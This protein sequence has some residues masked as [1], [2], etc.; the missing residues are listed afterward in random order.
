MLLRTFSKAS[1]LTFARSIL[2][3]VSFSLVAS[4]LLVPASHACTGITLKAKDGSVVYGRTMEWGSFDMESE[5]M[6][7]PPGHTFK[8]LLADGKWGKTW[9]AKFAVAGINGVGK[10]IVLDGINSA[11]LTIGLFY[12][13]GFA[14]YQKFDPAL[15]AESLAPTDVATYLLTTCDSV[16]AVRAALEKVRV[17]PVVEPALGIVAP[18]H[19]LVT[20]PSGRAI[21]VE[22]LRG[23]LKIFDAPL[24]TITNAP[25]YDWHETNLR[26]YV[27]LSAVSIPDKKIGDLDFKPLGGGNGSGMIGLPGDFTPPSR[28]IRA[29]AFTQTARPTAT[30]P[31]TMYELFRILDNFNVTAGAAE[32]HGTATTQPLRSA[33]Q[34]TTA[35]DTKSHT[36]YYH[37]MNNRRVRKVEL[38]QIK[39][40]DTTIL[41]QP[42]D[43]VKAEDIE[44]ATPGK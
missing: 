39:F 13:P 33:T 18:V 2:A 42:L 26:N 20:E 16:A 34:W 40:A 7:V 30:G 37:T 9:T 3:V 38:D 15:A 44:D 5:V 24:G 10:E 41:R 17:V 1:P 35:Y 12:H 23:E 32:G 28:F 27:N 29:V 11:G 19:F 8:S 25:S 43:K 14:E 36:L 6:I 22:Y 4:L 31:E 21:V